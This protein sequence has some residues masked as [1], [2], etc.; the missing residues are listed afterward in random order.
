MN[1][2]L[3]EVLSRESLEPIVE[4]Y[5]VDRWPVPATVDQLVGEVQASTTVTTQG[6]LGGKRAS[7]NSF[8]FDIA[9]RHPTRRWPP[10]SRTRSSS[11]SPR[12]TWS[13]VPTRR[14]SRPSS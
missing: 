6:N 4:R 1:G 13:S 5:V 14:G 10:T 8:V 7:T 11:P 12:S 3:A 9:S 2:I